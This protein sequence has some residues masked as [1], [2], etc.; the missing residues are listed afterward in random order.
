MHVLLTLISSASFDFLNTA[1]AI[2]GMAH[3][4][5]VFNMLF[6]KKKLFILIE[7]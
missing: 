6:L 7:G 5:L 1:F 3:I 2:I 4:F